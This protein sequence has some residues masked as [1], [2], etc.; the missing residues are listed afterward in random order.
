MVQ[1]I[2]RSSFDVG[3]VMVIFLIVRVIEYR[4]RF[5]WGLEWWL[6]S[7]ISRQ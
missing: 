4:F 6:N 1:G 5:T 3:E 7:I 2:F